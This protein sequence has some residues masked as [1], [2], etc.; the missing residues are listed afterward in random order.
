MQDRYSPRD[1]RHDGFLPHGFIRFREGRGVEAQTGV[2]TRRGYAGAEA[3]TASKTARSSRIGANTPPAASIGAR[4]ISCT[5]PS[6][7]STWRGS[8]W[9]HVGDSH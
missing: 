1:L 7:N 9:G 6:A 5:A 2:I 8:E 3:G 4:S